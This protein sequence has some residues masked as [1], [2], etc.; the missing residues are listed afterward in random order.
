MLIEAQLKFLFE[1]FKIC[2][3]KVGLLPEVFLLPSPQSDDE[4]GKCLFVDQR[5]VKG[6]LNHI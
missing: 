4:A 2:I 6:K 1:F 3:K 5:S